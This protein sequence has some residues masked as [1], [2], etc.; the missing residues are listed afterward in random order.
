MLPK[1]SI[2]IPN[3]N[4]LPLLR[5]CLA[6]IHQKTIY[7]NLEII[8]IE[9]GSTDKEVHDYYE[10]IQENFSDIKILTYTKPFNWSAIN[11]FAAR[12]SE[13]DYLLFLNNDIEIISK[14][15]IEKIIEAFENDKTIGAI[16]TTLWYPDNTIQHVGVK[17]TPQGQ[18][19]HND[20]KIQR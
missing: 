13:G 16:G 5:K 20:L 19:F 7:S 11:N 18:A 6:S 17:I 2:I 4:N 10:T 15:W 12:Q 9:N 8:I 1:I 3:Q 14:G